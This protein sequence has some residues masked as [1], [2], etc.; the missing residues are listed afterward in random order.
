MAVAAYDAANPSVRDCLDMLAGTMTAV[1]EATRSAMRSEL[2]EPA[3]QHLAETTVASLKPLIARA[4]A[5]INGDAEALADGAMA[6][7]AAVDRLLRR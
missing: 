1:L 4:G 5:V 3:A 2:P 6:P 7:Q